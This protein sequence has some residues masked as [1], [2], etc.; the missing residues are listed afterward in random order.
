MEETIRQPN[1]A[2]PE[3]PHMPP[4]SPPA[5]PGRSTL[6][7]LLALCTLALLARGFAYQGQSI[8]ADVPPLWELQDDRRVLS[9]LA[10]AGL[11]AVREALWFVPLGL[12]VALV[13]GPRRTI[14]ARFA[15]WLAGMAAAVAGALL[16]AAVRTG[17][18]E[19]MPSP[20]GLAVPAAGGV[21]GVRL[22]RAWTGGKRAFWLLALELV[23]VPIL[24]LIA[25]VGAAAI[26]LQAA[27]ASFQ[28]A[29]LTSPEKRRLVELIRRHNPQHIRAGE[30]QTLT[31]TERDVNLLLAWGL[32]LGSSERK[33]VATIEPDR[34]RLQVS[35][36]AP[37]GRL[38]YL[39][40]TLRGWAG[41]EGDALRVRI[42]DCRLGPWSV[43]GP[44]LRVLPRLVL[45]ELQRS[46]LA[47]P[48]LAAVQG[49]AIRPGAVSVT[50][51]PIDMPTGFREDL[52]GPMGASA[53]MTAAVEL[54]VR[55]LL[56][57][58]ARSDPRNVPL[59]GCMEAV[60][61]LASKRSVAGDPVL[62]NRAAILA[63]GTCLGH[64]RLQEFIGPVLKAANADQRSRA[65]LLRVTLRGRNDWSRHFMLSASIA[66]LSTEVVSDAA[67]LLKEEMDAG[68]GGSGFSFADLVADR[69]GTTFGLAA[70]QDATR[71]RAIQER[72]VAGFRADDF[73]P[74]AADLPEGI[75]DREFETVYGGVNGAKYKEL[76]AE[77]ERRINACA[78]Y[79]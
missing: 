78:G 4:D 55:E 3:P 48:A 63:L 33:A 25:G 32:S 56:A 5:R 14:S 16:A 21:L 73:M 7:A 36:P 50:Y 39:H 41:V 46:R 49:I 18:P 31:L 47:A 15:A 34:I 74:P 67:G 42:D 79:N 69:A 19:W 60:F 11:A 59:A 71:A 62:E 29:R 53:E 61:G 2:S 24:L 22:G 66:V 45:A 77:I 43:P 12:L 57:V 26:T 54:Y 65:A 8:W 76:M 64:A 30:T 35:L 20:L 28:P 6:M 58:V 9:W 40:A 17:P 52:F 72:I 75:R 38:G 23:L 68:A 70:T 27:P 1:P 13:M 37:G 10:A 44:I 51:G